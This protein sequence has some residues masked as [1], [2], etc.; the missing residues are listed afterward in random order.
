MS[1]LLN[2]LGRFSE[3]IE[4]AWSDTQKL[5]LPAS[6]RS[7][8][9]VVVMGMG[10]S[11][12]G[13]HVVKTALQS[14]CTLPIE[15]IGRY[16][17]PATATKK[18]L[19]IC[20]SFSGTTEE[21]LSAY[22][23]ARA[24][25]V[26]VFVLCA[27]GE[28]ARLAAKDRVPAY[29]FN[30]GELVPIDKNGTPHPRYGGGFMVFGVLGILSKLGFAKVSGG[31][32]AALAKHLQKELPRAKRVTPKLA[33]ELLGRASMIVASEHLEGAAHV[34]A[35]QINESTKH[36]STTFLLPEL[37]HHLMEGLQF[38]KEVIKKI[39]FVFLESGLYH[40]RVQKRYKLTA[41]VVKKNGAQVVRIT[42]NGKTPLEQAFELIQL[43]A[44]V[45]FE[46]A[47]LAKVD[48]EDI[49]WVIWFKKQLGK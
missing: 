31:E 15:V 37:N 24:K 38:P 39:T 10:G 12:L 33:K 22:K 1:N 44:F 9:N 41:D 28:L 3:Q 43:G 8:T 48:P 21:V 36:F 7:I 25:K 42:P 19:V 23:Q 5:V 35:N 20:S 32:V 29:V 40:P 4:Q 17:L 26:N 46:M 13:A 45:T 16:T 11:A 6:W 2:T 14:R 47:R 49:P 30:P 18:S 34:F 27:G